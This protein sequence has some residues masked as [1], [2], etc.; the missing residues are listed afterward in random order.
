M[1]RSILS[2]PI[3]VVIAVCLAACGTPNP[4]LKPV[5]AP[6]PIP[7]RAP[8]PGGETF[9]DCADCPSMVVL[10]AGRF[11]MGSQPDE[12][13]RDADEGPAIEVNLGKPFAIGR[14]EVTRGQFAAFV[15]ATGY[16]ATA[17]CL[18]W[19][20]ERLEAVAGRS[21]RDPLIVQRDD[22][23]VVCVSWRDA[24][25]Y[26][27]WLARSTGQSYRLPSNAEWEYAAR[28]GT[29]GAYAFPGGET[30]ACAYGNV[31]DRRAKAAVP[32]WRTADCDDGVGFG[33]APVGS[34]APNGFG[35][36]DTMGNVWEWMA[37]CYHANYAGTPTDGSAWGAAGDCG[38]AFDRGG[39]FTSLFPGHLRAANRSKAPSPDTAA[40]SLGFRVARDV[41]APGSGSR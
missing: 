36:H 21:W 24:T 14:F 10:P 13:N 25:A 6:G 26:A 16:V 33:T 38:E 15:R 28:G 5:P 39:G 35:L 12:P 2:A 40:Y 34:Y 19:T 18:V 41:G 37:D 22:H 32:A 30:G 17:Q 23:P 4:A 29:P 20:G 3:L 31:G 8:A 7:T 27:A 9:R 1:P 11:E